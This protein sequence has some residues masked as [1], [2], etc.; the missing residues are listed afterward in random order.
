MGRPMWQSLCVECKQMIMLKIHA[1]VNEING[2]ALKAIN[3]CNAHSA[4]FNAGYGG[5]I[6]LPVLWKH[7]MH[8]KMG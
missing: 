1:L 2:A 3:Q 4:W 7:Y 8:W 5:V 6:L